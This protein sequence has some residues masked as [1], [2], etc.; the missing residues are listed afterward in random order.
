MVN[1]WLNSVPFWLFP[2]CCVLCNGPGQVSLDLCISCQRDIPWLDL[3]CLRCGWPIDSSQDF[4]QCGHCLDQ[5]LP[6]DRAISLLEYRWPVD[7]MVIELKFEKNRA[8]ARVLGSLMAQLLPHHYNDQPLPKLITCVPM[9]P[10]RLRERGFNQAHLIARQVSRILGI[11]YAPQ[12]ARRTRHSKAQSGLTAQQRAANIAGCFDCDLPSQGASS[13]A[14][15]DD[16]FTTGSTVGELSKQFRKTGVE[17]I[18]IWTVART[19]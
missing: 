3:T 5:A 9:H 14:I 19:L 4:R 15:I 1:N 6:Y 10:D 18:D 13:I 8:H 12:I 16:V 17:R 11:P 7:Q 2:P